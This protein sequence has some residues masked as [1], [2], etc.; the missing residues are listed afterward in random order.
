MLTDRWQHVSE[1]LFCCHVLKWI[2]SEIV[3]GSVQIVLGAFVNWLETA[4]SCVISVSLSVHIS[5][6]VSEG[7][8]VKFYFGDFMK[9]R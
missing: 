7:S 5:W 2:V 1:C 4:V 9:I 8:F 3:A 6:C